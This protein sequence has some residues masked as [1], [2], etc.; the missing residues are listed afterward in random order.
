MPVD[1][2]FEVRVSGVVVGRI[3]RNPAGS[4]R[5]VPDPNWL[6]AGQRPRLG[7]AFL[8]DP[9]VRVEGGRLPTWFENLLPERGSA[10]RARLCRDAGLRE[11]QSADLLGY[12]GEDLPGAVEVIGDLSGED[13]PVREVTTEG[14]LRVSLA[15]LQLK[16]SMVQSGDRYALPAKGKLGRW[17]VKLPGENYPLLPQIEHATLAWAARSGLPTPTAEVVP[18]DALDGVPP[19][20]PRSTEVFAIE[21]FDRTSDGGRIHQEDLCQVLEMRPE[22]KYADDPR[23]G[24]R[25]TSMDRL[26]RL[27]RDVVGEHGVGELIDRAAFVVASGNTDAHLKNWAILWSSGRGAEL[28]PLYDQVACVALP[29]QGWARGE[30]E[31]ALPIGTVRGL[32]GLTAPA[33]RKFGLRSSTPGASDRFVEALSRFREH[34]DGAM[35]DVMR[36]ALR[37]HWMRVPI[38]RAVGD[39][40]G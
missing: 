12:L 34:F 20:W 13:D 28:A 18:I 25:R 40:P 33:L 27:V 21:R 1:R 16:L 23:G 35:P 9:R 4:V 38:L 26:V 14:R 31:L 24:N 6:A 30:L 17:I 29:G 2:R 36:T 8:T 22:H 11:E 37:E 7:Y 32:S 15:G 5:F 39:L 19:E 10:L 3:D